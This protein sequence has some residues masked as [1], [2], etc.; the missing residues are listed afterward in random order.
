MKK[1]FNTTGV[2]VPR[3]HYMVNIENKL[4]EIIELIDNE[5]YFTINRPRQ[6][7]KTTTL[8][9]L[10]NLL[11]E[12]YI[13]ISISF[14]GIGDL[15]FKKEHDF[16]KAFVE[17]I[18][19]SLA[20]EYEEESRK[21][22]NLGKNIK[23]IKDLSKVI[24]KFV[25]DCNKEV[26]LLIDEVDKSSNNQLFLSFIGM[27]RNKYLAR[28]IGKDYTFKSVILAGVHDVKTLKA[29][30]RSNETAKYNSPWNIA[31]D[32]NV[33]MSFSSKEISTMLQEYVTEKNITMDVDKISDELHFY[34]SGYPFLVSKLCQ[35]IDE[36]IYDENK[37]CWNEDY[38]TKAVKILNE[39]TNTLFE[40]LVKNLENREE[41][42]N[43]T[44]R[45]L[46]DGE[47]IIF[48]PL[49][50]VISIGLTYGIFKRG[51]YGVEI[52]NKIFEEII[53]NYMLSKTRTSTGKMSLYNFKDNFL[54]EDG[55]LDIEKI[56][57]RFMQFMKEQYSGKNE[58]F[59][60]THGR[61]LFLA[62]IKPIINGVGFDFK[63]VQISE[64]KRLDIVI[65]YNS[66]KY[67]IEMKIWRGK[68][69]H[70]KGIKQL[71]DYLDIH[72]LD[73]GYLVIF[74]F[75]KEKE[76]KAEEINTD[77]KNIFSV[78]V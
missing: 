34:T 23:D 42:Y 31:V 41:L 33:D 78:F 16:V 17:I 67:I 76:Y 59:L 25:K 36:R 73:K 51:K 70:E 5:C 60:E 29:K 24:T 37:K 14:E 72:D 7:G 35:I 4:N 49:D 44:K 64:E 57:R 8:T 46:I 75:N 74:N 66:F 55:S 6:Y 30:L 68:K 53:Y 26:V 15:V 48:N 47:V 38:V 39:E 10:D 52:G 32:F 2:C 28:E 62:F 71:C 43:L 13:M 18:S 21:I 65:T 9:Q 11:K 50:P 22:L 40:S 20:F 63:E 45:I 69:Y 19:D 56:L 3:K 54:R 27:L 1:R 77:N 61:L 58:E 12:Q